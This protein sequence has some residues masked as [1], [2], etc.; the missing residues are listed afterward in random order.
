M[1]AAKLTSKAK[2]AKPKKTAQPRASKN[3][4]KKVVT[5]TPQEHVPHPYDSLPM[6]EPSDGM[7]LTTLEDND[8]EQS[9]IEDLYLEDDKVENESCSD[10]LDDASDDETIKVLDSEPV[11]PVIIKPV[12]QTLS[13][14]G[15]CLPKKRSTPKSARGML[16]CLENEDI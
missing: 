5:Q 14:K 9:A 12:K 1:T 7:F 11:P 4:A 15:I 13:S 3:T 6:Q 2:A 16:L 8:L 10:M